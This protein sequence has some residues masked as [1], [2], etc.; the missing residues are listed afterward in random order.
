MCS[1]DV[2]GGSVVNDEPLAD[3]RHISFHGKTVTDARQAAAKMPPPPAPRPPQSDAELD[4]FAAWLL[5]QAG[6]DPR[7]YRATPL[8]RRVAT[9]LRRVRASDPQE[10]R[11]HLLRRPDQLP[12]AVDTLLI[13][14]T[15]FHRDETVFASLRREVMPRL[16]RQEGA[17]RVWSAGCANGAELYSVAML[18]AEWDLLPR[19]D[20]LG[21]DCRENAVTQA[22]RAVYPPSMLER[23]DPGLT[24]HFVREGRSWRVSDDVRRQATWKLRDLTRRAE[25]GPWDVILFRN[26]AIYLTEQTTERIYERLADVL[27]PGGFLVTGKAEIPPLAFARLAPCLYQWTGTT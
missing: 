11:A 18:L 17:I 26:L 21:T 13:G 19:A 7:A 5:W 10:A 15:E 4:P 20:L 6:L 22:Q 12:V 2:A 16:A 27:R 8:N 24:D 9:C 14:V 25:P 3:L 23:L 1:S